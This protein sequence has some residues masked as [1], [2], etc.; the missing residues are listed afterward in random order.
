MNR[1]VH[2]TRGSKVHAPRAHCEIPPR[3]V[4]PCGKTALEYNGAM[5]MHHRWVG[6]CA[7]LAGACSGDATPAPRPT[8]GIPVSDLEHEIADAFCAFVFD[9]TPPGDDENIFARFEL[10][11][12]ERCPSLIARFIA[13]DGRVADLARAIDEGTVRY[14]AAAARACVEAVRAECARTTIEDLGELFASRCAGVFEGTVATGGACWVSEECEGD[15]WC[16]H[17]STTLPRACPGTCAPRLALGAPCSGD[18]MCTREGLEGFAAC[19]LDATRVCIERRVVPAASAGGACG[20]SRDGDVETVAPCGAGL[21][22]DGGSCSE[23]LGEGSPCM[24]HS[25][26]APGLGCV[27]GACRAVSFQSSAGA[28]CD[29]ATFCDVVAHLRCAAGSCVSFG[30]GAVGTACGGDAGHFACDDGLV[31]SG[32]GCAPPLEAGAP[33]DPESAC[34]CDPAT[35]TCLAR[36]CR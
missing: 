17:A 3:L 28:P 21:W 11:T 13:Q 2:A 19:S 22:C 32:T 23:P 7:L 35:A 34:E 10:L 20:R 4:P 6:L 33:C 9:C 25:V 8:A 26:C 30:D 14:D 18:E 27:D 5:M 12:R 31:C 15:A 36:L 1:L 24:E 29:T 16:D